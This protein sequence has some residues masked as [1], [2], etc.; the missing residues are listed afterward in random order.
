MYKLFNI[1]CTNP[2][3]PE[4]GINTLLSVVLHFCIFKSSNLKIKIIY[5]LFI[6][7]STQ[8]NHLY[9]K[10]THDDIHNYFLIRGTCLCKV[11]EK[12]TFIF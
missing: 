1:L 8:Y 6:L 12:K 10:L 7:H 5:Y 2:F 4:G 11:F 9:F 3:M